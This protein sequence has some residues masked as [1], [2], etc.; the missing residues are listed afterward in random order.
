MTEEQSARPSREQMIADLE[1]IGRGEDLGANA[2]SAE[3][4][5]EGEGHEPEE[6]TESESEETTEETEQLEDSEPDEDEDL[7][8]PDGEPDE[9]EGEDEPDPE[10]SKGLAAIQKQEKRFKERMQQERAAVAK[11]REQAT[12]LHAQA[13]E[14]MTKLQSMQERAQYDP[15]GVL[16]ELGLSEEAFEDAA[17]QVYQR[18]PNAKPGNKAAAAESMR[19][20]KMEAQIAAQEKRYQD[21]EARYQ[22][23]ASQRQVDDFLSKVTSGATDETPLARSLIGAN[24]TKA[25]RQLHELAVY[26]SEEFGEVPEPGEVL[27]AYERQRRTELEEMGVDPDELISKRGKAKAKVKAKPS[28]TI[29]AEVGQRTRP[30]GE[31][32]QLSPEELREETIRELESML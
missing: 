23:D 19:V 11:E 32:R 2:S 13:T 9:D 24:P 21:L 29:S 31:E 12:Q 26:L 1:S 16:E 27:K 15:A 8:E 10:A 7:E 18:S 20:R 3:E 30:P 17:K 14:V 22:S 4:T 6:T 28:K 5:G 25:K